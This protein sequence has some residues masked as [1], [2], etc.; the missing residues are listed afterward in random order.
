M[1][2]HVRRTS[3]SRLM[4]VIGSHRWCGVGLF[5]F[6]KRARRPETMTTV[7]WHYVIDFLRARTLSLNPA[8]VVGDTRSHRLMPQHLSSHT[9]SAGGVPQHVATVSINLSDSDVA[10]KWRAR[11]CRGCN[12]EKTT[13]VCEVGRITPV[14]ARA[15]RR[16]RVGGSDCMSANN[17]TSSTK[18]ASRDTPSHGKRT[19][20]LVQTQRHQFERQRQRACSRLAGRSTCSLRRP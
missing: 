15:T 11:Q 4:K 10:L 16:D 6:P 5:L 1:I 3:G 17:L 2:Q 12:D 7:P 18:K 8:G 20:A 14:G 19:F 9:A 13:P